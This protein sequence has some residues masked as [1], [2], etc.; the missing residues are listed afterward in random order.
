MK[1]PASLHGHSHN[2]S[3]SSHPSSTPLAAPAFGEDALAFNSPAAALIASIG[4]QG[5]TP[6]PSGQDGLGISTKSQALST[7]EGSVG[8][9]RDMEEE[10]LRNLQEVQRL[11]KTRLAGRAICREGVQ[12][13]AQH[14]N[15]TFAWLDDNN[16]SIAGNC[17]D[18]EIVFDEAQRDSVNDV[19]LKINTSGVEEHKKDA[20]AVLQQ[21]LTPSD[22]DTS[23]TPWKNLEA[24]SANLAR[25]A[26]LDH[27]SN[28]LNCF[29]AIDGLYYSFQ[30]IWVEERKR[31]RSKHV[32]SRICGGTLGRPAMHKKRKLGLSLD[33]WVENRRTRETKQKPPRAD[34]MDVDQVDLE[35]DQDEESSPTWLARIG[36]ETGYPPIRVS[37]DWVSEEVFQISDADNNNDDAQDETRKPIWLD[38]NPTLVVS[39][40]EIDVGDETV[41]EQAVAGVNS[42]PKPPNIRFTFDLEPAVLLTNSAVSTMMTQG[43]TLGLDFSKASTYQ[44]A[45]HDLGSKQ[46]STQSQHGVETQRENANKAQKRWTRDLTFYDRDG[47]A[48]QARHSYAL[49][50]SPPVGVYPMQSFSFEH[51][52]QLAEV[53]PVLRQYALLWSIMCK[54]TPL[55]D[56]LAVEDPA[57][58]N[59]LDGS[60]RP[61]KSRAPQKKSNIN[62]QHARLDAFLNGGGF[63]G[64]ETGLTSSSSGDGEAVVS[65]DVLLNETLTNPPK[66]KLD[67]IFPLPLSS[68]KKVSGRI[69]EPPGFGTVSIEIEVNGRIVVSS[70]TGLPFTDS[71]TLGKLA[72][73]LSL[74]EDLGV[75]VQ[76]ILG[77][78]RAG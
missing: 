40:N 77:R 18:L 47:L 52:R 41:I 43:L 29:E 53:I 51:P 22:L 10:K 20:S 36:C 54:L 58:K 55:S 9:K 48:K 44:Q 63:P 65:I 69:R 74:G 57:P 33:Y 6:L 66:P 68:D 73:V 11:L 39:P 16:L 23:V 71:E 25:L 38:P 8:G 60:Q 31:L 14:S 1:T 24:F 35:L 21:D 5:L 76:W 37:K 72:T 30:R 64:G 13:I 2:V 59:E 70:A 45:F 17:V 4:S 61:K 12:R 42:L 28:R 15:L 7:K 32:L 49:H 3:T 62:A 78:L 27:L 75:L 67:I 26:H 56:T 19:V 50:S 34:A 46:T